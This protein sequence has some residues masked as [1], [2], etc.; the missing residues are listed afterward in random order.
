MVQCGVALRG[1]AWCGVM[2]CGVVRFGTALCDMISTVWQKG[3]EMHAI[4]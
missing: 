2:W 1:A 4:F 3:F